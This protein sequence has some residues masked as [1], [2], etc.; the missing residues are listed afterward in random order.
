M[1]NPE[2]V[3]PHAKGDIPCRGCASEAA[4]SLQRQQGQ[5][6]LKA[7]RAAHAWMAARPEEVLACVPVAGTAL[8][9][10]ECA[11]A[12]RPTLVAEC[13]EVAVAAAEDIPGTCAQL[14]SI[15]MP[16]H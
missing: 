11:K 12:V 13:A 15:S 16:S 10:L 9:H 14:P 4:S 3:L 7:G 2:M 5:G 8:P 1:N 6:R